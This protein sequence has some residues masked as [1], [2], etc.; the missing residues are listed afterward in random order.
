MHGSQMQEGPISHIVGHNAPSRSLTRPAS[1]MQKNSSHSSESPDELL[2]AAKYQ[3]TTTSVVQ[4][5]VLVLVK[6]LGMVF[7]VLAAPINE[8]SQ[9][10]A[11]RETNR[12]AP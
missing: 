9:T 12:A 8:L 3:Y 4:S 7:R 2:H 10:R 5:K 11:D 6:T 1:I